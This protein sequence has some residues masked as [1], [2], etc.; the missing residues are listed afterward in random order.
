MFMLAT[1]NPGSRRARHRRRHKRGCACVVCSHRKSRRSSRRRSGGGRRKLSAWQRA[2][3]KFG[4]VMQAL[5]HRKKNSRRSAVSRRSRRG[6]S[7]RHKKEVTH[8]A[9]ATRRRR[10]RHNMPP[11]GR[12]GRFL[13]RGG[14]RRRRR[15]NSW[16]KQP[17]RHRRAARLGIRRRRRHYAA[18]PR[19]RRHYRRNAVLPVSWNPHRRRRRHYRRNAVL[20]ISWNPG[21]IVGDITGK[22]KSF[23][24]VRFLTQTAVPATAGFLA[25]KVVGN[26]VADQIAGF[27]KVAPTDRSYPF[28]RIGSQALT[29][30]GLSYAIGRFVGREQGKAAFLG[31]AIAVLHSILKEIVPVS[32]QSKYGL[33]DGLGSD[34]T[35]RMRDAVQRR[36][37]ERLNGYGAYLN[38]TDLRPQPEMGAYVNLTDLRRQPAFAP[39]PSADLRDYDVTR[40]ETA[41]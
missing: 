11:R 10:R 28:V 12:S 2:V 21:G 25:T 15:R 37:E 14:G 16:F 24:D 39:S 26:M 41:L 35:A 3:K 38:R 13:R 33:L 4:G 20:P 27:V 9:R 29:A 6:R 22:V 23:I 31:G 36:V 1:L 32:D 19:R 5:K 7:R 18:N 8:M 34:L 17:I 30:A 40:T